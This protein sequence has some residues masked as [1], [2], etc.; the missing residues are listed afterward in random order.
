MTGNT[1]NN[2]WT[3][4]QQRFRSSA[5]K[6]NMM[7]NTIASGK[8][9]N[10]ARWPPQHL[11]H[12]ILWNFGLEHMQKQWEKCQTLD[13]CQ[14]MKNLGLQN[15]CLLKFLVFPDLLCLFHSD[16]SKEQQQIAF[17]PLQAAARHLPAKVENAARKQD[18]CWV[19]FKVIFPQVVREAFQP[20]LVGGWTNPS[21]NKN[22]QTW[23]ISPK[24]PDEHS[25][26]YP[27]KRPQTV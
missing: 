25:K 26:N 22:S 2:C 7:A 1:L 19:K 4:L 14:L 17:E 12:W 10:Q 6:G 20:F 16:S 11:R 21:Q 5:W 18:E 23:I 8:G 3:L 15:A 27:G 13:M 9:P 24:D